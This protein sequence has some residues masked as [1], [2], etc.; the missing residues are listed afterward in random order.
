MVALA[1]LANDNQRHVETNRYWSTNQQSR[2]TSYCDTVEVLDVWAHVLDRL[3]Y[4]V[5][6]I[7]KAIVVP[8]VDH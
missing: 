5:G 1:W 4:H 3:V 2:G 6:Q 7:V 8:S